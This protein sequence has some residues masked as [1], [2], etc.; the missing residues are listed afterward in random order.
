MI[1]PLEAGDAPQLFDMMARVYANHSFLDQGQA[2]YV[3]QIS[4]GNYVSL[5]L[6]DGNTLKA[7]AGYNVTDEYALLNTLV[8]D[9]THRSTGLGA[10]IFN[11]RLKHIVNSDMFRFVVGYSMMQHIKSQRLYDD[12]FMPIGMDIGYPDIYQ[13]DQGFNCGS[14]ANAELILCKRLALGGE[15]PIIPL[16]E[17]DRPLAHTILGALGITPTFTCG[18]ATGA[19]FLGFHP[20]KTGELYLP[21]YLDPDVLA[22]FSGAQASNQRRQDFVTT[23]EANYHG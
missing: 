9:P 12:D 18:T 20:T 19:S 11:A 22:D 16:A 17:R 7:H 8:V 5:G 21:A 10:D 6:F 13:Q 14:A 4:N 15:Q 23:I 3:A 2:Q 1:R